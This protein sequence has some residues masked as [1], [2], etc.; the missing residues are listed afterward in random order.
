[1]DVLGSVCGEVVVDDEVDLLDV[2]ASAQEIG[3]DQ[4]SRGS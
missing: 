4:D 1:M 3:R 2:D